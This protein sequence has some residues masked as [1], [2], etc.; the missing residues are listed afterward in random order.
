MR[1]YI[2]GPITNRPD[3]NRA[4]FAEAAEQLKAAGHEPINPL[5]YTTQDMSWD[6]CMR[7]VIPKMLEC[8][9]VATLDGFLLSRGAF[10]EVQLAV[11]V[12]IEC[13]P[14]EEWL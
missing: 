11:K 10:L 3:N 6:E 14:L 9:G 1:I 5:D 2:S 12:G 4:A 13:K 8:D 7:T